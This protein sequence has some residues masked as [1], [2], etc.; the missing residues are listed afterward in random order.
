[1]FGPVDDH[2]LALCD[3]RSVD[4]ADPVAVDLVFPHYVSELYKVQHNAGQ[5]WS[6]LGGQ[7]PDEVWIVKM[8]DSAASEANGIS[9]CKS[10]MAG[11]CARKAAC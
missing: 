6:Y 4:R 7:M 3:A 8:C 1:M 11:C 5:Q 2:P 9:E 10:T